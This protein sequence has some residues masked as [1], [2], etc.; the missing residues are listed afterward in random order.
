MLA[1]SFMIG[2]L[3]TTIGIWKWPNKK[4]YGWYNISYTLRMQKGGVILRQRVR[5]A[6]QD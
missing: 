3:L 5:G 1:G 2:Y 6:I 4:R